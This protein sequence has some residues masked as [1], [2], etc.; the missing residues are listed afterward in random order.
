MR[1]IDLQQHNYCCLSLQLCVVCGVLSFG[2]V[3]AT[4][5]VNSNYNIPMPHSLFASTATML[6]VA[7]SS[8]SND[9]AFS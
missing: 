3:F 9:I 2:F 6:V 7:N 8:N 4:N 1:F 5:C